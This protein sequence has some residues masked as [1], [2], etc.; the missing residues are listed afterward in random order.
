M[1]ER[2][3]YYKK[4]SDRPENRK[5]I[6]ERS[7]EYYYSHR[8]KM[9]KRSKEWRNDNI[10]SWEKVIPKVN[11]CQV[12]GKRILFN[13]GDKRNTVHFDHRNNGKEKIKEHPSTW[14]RNN[15]YSIEN[16]KIWNSCNFGVVC[17]LCNKFM[18]TGGRKKWW[19]NVGRY[20]CYML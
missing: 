18:P 2:T 3:E 17:E 20:M 11:R 9:I 8:D 13:T 7:K 15:K 4:W 19:E 1:A 10:T 12:C 5:R 14:L 6:I 16:E